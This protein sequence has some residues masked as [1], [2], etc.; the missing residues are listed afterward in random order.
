VL[1]VLEVRVSAL[2]DHV[3]VAVTSRYPE[4]PNHRGE[5]VMIGTLEIVRA[6]AM[7]EIGYRIPE[8]YA[9]LEILRVLELAEAAASTANVQPLRPRHGRK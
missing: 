8:Q 6:R 3:R 9:D 5:S 2:A 4:A 1:E 7:E